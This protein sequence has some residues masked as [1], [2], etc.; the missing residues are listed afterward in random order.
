MD[1][2]LNQALSKA[3]AAYADKVALRALIQLIPHVGGPI[4]TLFAGKGI[5]LQNERLKHLIQELQQQFISLQTLPPYN[6]EE[7]LDLVIRAMECAVKTRVKEKRAAYASI[8]AKHVADSKNIEESEI[9]LRIISELD[10]I[11]FNILHE[12]LSVPLSAE[13]FEGLRAFSVSSKSP[14]GRNKRQ[15]PSL[16]KLLPQYSINILRSACSELLSKGLLH[17]EGIGRWDMGTMEI[18]VP[19]ETADWL[20]SWL[21]RSKP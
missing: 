20:Q 12:A 10:L 1:K 15:L 2:N 21:V 19:T 13:P 3:S 6:E 14:N 4:D 17:D 9:A 18:F 7:F 8:V 11:H 16:Q 5:K